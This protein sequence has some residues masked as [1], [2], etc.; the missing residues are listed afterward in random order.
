VPREPQPISAPEEDDTENEIPRISVP[1]P[2]EVTPKP[3]ERLSELKSQIIRTE[4]FNNNPKPLPNRNQNH[5]NNDNRN[6]K[7]PKPKNNT[8]PVKNNHPIWDTVAN[9]EAEKKKLQPG[10][11]IILGGGYTYPK[12][13][14]SKTPLNPGEV[15]KL[16]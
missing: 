15:H 1:T 14:D 3:Q 10:D 4:K 5:F 13:D 12:P 6:F 7:K 8:K 16:T 9:I 11:T 2:A